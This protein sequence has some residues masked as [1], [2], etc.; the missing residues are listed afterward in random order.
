MR[1]SRAIASRRAANRVTLALAR[2]QIRRGFRHVLAIAADALLR[3]LRGRRVVLVVR[4]VGTGA[5]YRWSGGRLSGAAAPISVAR[6]QPHEV[7][8]CFLPADPPSWS[9]VRRGERWS[10]VALDAHGARTS[11]VAATDAAT[12]AESVQASK[13]LLS[14]AVARR[15]EWDGRLVVIDPRIPWNRG[16]G[17]FA[18]RQ[19]VAAAE[20][21][22]DNV[23]LLH[24]LRVRSAASERIR[25]ARELHDG[26]IQSVM[27]VQ[28]QLHALS[29]RLSARAH[30]IAPDLA[31]L[32]AV[33]RD[34]ALNLRDMMHGMQPSDLEPEHLVDAI[35]ATVKRFQHDS[36]ISARFVSNIDRLA[37]PPR[38]CRELTHV[39]HEALVNVR[40]HS[41]A[42]E[43]KVSLTLDGGACVLS[44]ADD[45][46]G[47]AFSG[48]LTEQD[49]AFE[50]IGPR[51]IRD[52]VRLIGGQLRVVSAPRR[53]TGPSGAHLLV[54][55]PIADGY[56]I[57]G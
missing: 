44:V 14:L 45:G 30:P 53:G 47:F 38:A 8:R 17:L 49:A 40:K 24:R 4:E 20:I 12:V 57:A 54:T 31:R 1:V 3:E 42:S 50:R 41:R 18:A 13:H 21:A 26:I 28:I 11:G 10:V 2:A 34:E 7:R 23:Y 43:V 16:A 39:V 19:L 48:L 15:G 37:L 33:L 27:G 55:I 51:V 32:A 29:A 52:R 25:I 5:A 9:A 56:A 35:A 6:L 46:D 22:L 36:G